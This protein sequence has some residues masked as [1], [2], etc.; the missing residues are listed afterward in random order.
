MFQI[1][2]F[3]VFGGMAHKKR[4]GVWGT[5]YKT[6]HVPT[7]NTTIWTIHQSLLQ[8]GSS[9]YCVNALCSRIRFFFWNHCIIVMYKTSAS[10]KCRCKKSCLISLSPHL[11][12]CPLSGF[13]S[14]SKLSFVYSFIFPR[15]SPSVHH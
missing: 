1:M 8:T 7:A 4:W 11:K 6:K 9:R 3:L 12:N 5:L 15:N 14:F 2:T 10:I 13:Y